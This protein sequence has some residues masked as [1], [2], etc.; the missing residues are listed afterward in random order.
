MSSFVTEHIAVIEADTFKSV[1]ARRLYDYIQS[2]RGERDRPTFA[3]I[4]LMDLYDI[5]S[6]LCIRDVVDGGGNGGDMMCRYWGGDFQWAYKVNCM[7]KLISETYDPKGAQNTLALHK[8]ALEAERPLRLV[9][10][11]GYADKT[12]EHVIFEGIMVSVDGK[13]HPRQH[14][15]AVGQF[16]YQLDE[17]DRNLLQVQTGKRFF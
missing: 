1:N 10:S 13:D 7:G 5:A 2:K 8:R 14:I 9:G 15:F 17:E 12:I 3:D 4:D 6:S 16:D 11:L